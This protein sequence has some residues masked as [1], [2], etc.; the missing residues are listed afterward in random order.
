MGAS[1]KAKAV[2]PVFVKA[3]EEVVSLSAEPV[4]V[5]KEEVRQ[6]CVMCINSKSS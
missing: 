1:G 4:K 3:K 5:V 2:V 6:L